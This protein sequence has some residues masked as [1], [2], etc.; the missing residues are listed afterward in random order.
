MLRYETGDATVPKGTGPKVLCHVCNDSGYWGA[1]FVLALSKKWPEPEATYKKDFAHG[2]SQPVKLGTVQFVS[3]TASEP[4]HVA[5]MIAQ[6]SVRPSKDGSP[7]GCS[8]LRYDALYD[9]LKAV[10]EFAAQQKAT[11]HCPRF[12]AGL[13][14]GKW[15]IIE[16]LIDKLL[17]QAHGLDVTVYDLEIL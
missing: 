6:R 9:C 3:V 13:A 14:G 16:M 8:P 17:V 11:V 2:V 4:L 12:G 15:E 1:G 5:N 10:G 7:D